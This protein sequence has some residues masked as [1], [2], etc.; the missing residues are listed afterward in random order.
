M[1]TMFGCWR[2]VLYR[3]GSDR[4]DNCRQIPSEYHQQTTNGIPYQYC[5]HC[6][7]RCNPPKAYGS[8]G[9]RN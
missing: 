8:K 1:R 3:L 4:C 9:A 5:F 7:S 6:C 2:T